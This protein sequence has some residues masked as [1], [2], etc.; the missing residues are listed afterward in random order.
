MPVARL[1]PLGVERR[2]V[3][4][5]D[6]TPVQVPAPPTEVRAGRRLFA[7]AAWRETAQFLASPVGVLLLS[8]ICLGTYLRFHAL[9]YP[10]G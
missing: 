10:P 4:L 3:A 2:S 6:A 8:M 7:P 1:D 5:N 9:G